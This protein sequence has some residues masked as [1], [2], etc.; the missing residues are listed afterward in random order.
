HAQIGE[1]HS[2]AR[3][4]PPVTKSAVAVPMNSASDAVPPNDM[5]SNQS[6][7]AV[8]GK[9]PIH[10]ASR[11]S[12]NWEWYNTHGTSSARTPQPARPTIALRRL[13]VRRKQ[14]EKAAAAN[15]QPK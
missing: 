2:V 10:P 5:Y 13:S 14:V 4:Q 12:T 8:I 15:R 9:R 3:R 7:E 11:T 6:I 1:F